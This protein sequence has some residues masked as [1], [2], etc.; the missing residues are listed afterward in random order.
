MYRRNS[1]MAPAEF[2]RIMRVTLHNI[3]WDDGRGYYFVVDVNGRMLVH[4]LMPELENRDVNDLSDMYGVKIIAGVNQLCKNEAGGYLSYYWR[5]S[6]ESDAQALK[7]TCVRPYKPLGWNIGCG[8]YL[9]DA[10]DVLKADAIRRMRELSFANGGG[11]VAV[12][13][14]DG[15]QLANRKHEELNGRSILEMTDSD[16]K[17]MIRK[18]LEEGKKP[19]GGFVSYRYPS[20]DNSKISAKLSY[21]RFVPDWNWAVV[22]NVFVDDID[23]AVAVQRAE[24]IKR[25]IRNLLLAVSLGFAL[26][27]G[28]LLFSNM[29]SRRLGREMELFESF[30]SKAANSGERM[31]PETMRFSEFA[32][33]AESANR[34]VEARDKTEKALRLYMKLIEESTNGFAVVDMGG[35]IQYVNA[36]F[37]RMLG[38]SV[39]EELV[40]GPL[41]RHLDHKS[42]VRMDQEMMPQVK[43]M[44]QWSGEID[45]FGA[46]GHSIRP[47][48]RSS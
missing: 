24:L 13:T 5:K 45:L 21:S 8:E 25:M 30:F 34:M 38:K 1:G 31:D 37:L 15:V 44:G 32:R 4:P 47:F 7:M 9:D 16:G 33:L 35:D 20:A 2:E 29:M 39:A 48:A 46:N 3:R 17:K 19:E 26:G 41:V 28:T 18:I 23:V 40:G 42:V 27:V 43:T 11:A 22:A 6:A 14:G 10:E 36:A 12:V